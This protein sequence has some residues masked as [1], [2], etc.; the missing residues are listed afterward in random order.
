MVNT[1]SQALKVGKI[2]AG[3]T[4]VSSAYTGNFLG[5]IQDIKI[6]KKALYTGCF[7]TAN[8]LSDINTALPSDPSCTEI[9]MH[10]Q[11]NVNTKQHIKLTANIR[12][13]GHHNTAYRNGT[14]VRT[15]NFYINKD[16][17]IVDQRFVHST[18]ERV[19]REEVKYMVHVCKTALCRWNDSRCSTQR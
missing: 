5:Y 4:S 7:I 6:T 2:F 11:S 13:H 12:I 15:M 17:T 8:S 1:S 9:D 3:G 10:L 18:H 16:E 19:G 14:Y